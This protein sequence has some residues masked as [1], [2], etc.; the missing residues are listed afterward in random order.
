VH[1]KNNEWVYAIQDFRRALELD[2]G[3]TRAQQ[4]LKAVTN[5]LRANSNKK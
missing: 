5:E 1:T 3:N 4:F 2:P